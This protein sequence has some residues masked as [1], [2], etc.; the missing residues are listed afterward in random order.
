MVPR[1]ASPQFS[2]NSCHLSISEKLH[3][4]GIEP[5]CLET[6]F[7]SRDYVLQEDLA[8]AQQI[9]SVKRH[10]ESEMSSKKNKKIINSKVINKVRS[11]YGRLREPSKFYRSP[12]TL[13]VRKVRAQ[14]N[15][16]KADCTSIIE[17]VDECP[18]LTSLEVAAIEYVKMHSLS[19]DKVF[20]HVGDIYLK[21]AWMDCLIR[22]AEENGFRKWIPDEVRIEVELIFIKLFV[23]VCLKC[24]K[25]SNNNFLSLY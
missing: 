19:E 9:S 8:S 16:K 3:S 20:V 23:K 21:A 12:Y 11:K 2:Q 15:I 25:Y 22:P 18:T 17:L 6:K 13:P 7:F 24:E 5:A 1:S 4:R 14:R 10:S